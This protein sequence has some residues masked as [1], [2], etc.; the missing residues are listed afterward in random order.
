[1]LDLIKSINEWIWNIILIGLG[2]PLFIALVGT[3]TS[4]IIVTVGFLIRSF[5]RR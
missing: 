1:M 4:A 3:G 2:V 5:F